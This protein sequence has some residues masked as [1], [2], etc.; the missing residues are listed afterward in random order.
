MLTT[1]TKTNTKGWKPPTVGVGSGK[2][3][4]QNRDSVRR[5]RY[6]AN[7][8]FRTAEC[9]ADANGP[10]W[11]NGHHLEVKI[12]QNT[13]KTEAPTLSELILSMNEVTGPRWCCSPSLQAPFLVILGH[14]WFDLGP[15]RSR[16]VQAKFDP[17]GPAG[18]KYVLQGERGSLR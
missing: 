11:A 17:F 12:G 18:G 13:T 14:F 7:L 9:K 10:N 8:G 2:Q 15:G 3:C 5:A 4:P 1:S 16:P 6:T